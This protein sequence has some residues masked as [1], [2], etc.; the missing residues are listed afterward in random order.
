MVFQSLLPPIPDLP[1]PNAHYFFLN[2]P[3]QAEW[4]DYILHVD[5]LTGKTRR[6]SDFKDRVKR[7]ATAFGN[8]N[9]FPRGEKEIVGILSENC[10]VSSSK[11]SPARS[12]L[13]GRFPRMWGRT[14]VGICGPRPFAVGRRHSVRPVPS[15]ADSVRTEAP[16]QSLQSQKGVYEPSES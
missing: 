1:F 10:V 11:L 16:L 12:V 6:W 4:K 13:T 14:R 7:A 2:R 5:A 9:L 8:P 15:I 3:D